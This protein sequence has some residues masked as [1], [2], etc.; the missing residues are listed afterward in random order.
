MD[1]SV[2]FMPAKLNLSKNLSAHKDLKVYLAA[3][4]KALEKE[5]GEIFVVRN[6]EEGKWWVVD[7]DFEFSLLEWDITKVKDTG[8]VIY[9]PYEEFEAAKSAALLHLTQV[10]S[11]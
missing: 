7:G 4:L 2:V 9:G 5:P 8:H 3:D 1:K 11:S 10:G 6:D